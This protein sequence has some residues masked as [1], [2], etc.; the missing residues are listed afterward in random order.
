MK[1]NPVLNILCHLQYEYF[2]NNLVFTK[3]ESNI[4]L[5]YGRDAWV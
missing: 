1:T 5:L 2:E 3:I 4:A